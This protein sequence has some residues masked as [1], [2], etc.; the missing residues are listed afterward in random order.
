[1]SLVSPTQGPEEKQQKNIGK[2]EDSGEEVRGGLHRKQKREKVVRGG[3]KK[4]GG[5]GSQI[6]LRN[7]GGGPPDVEYLF[8]L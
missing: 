1:L 8:S 3:G 2:R 5:E 7:I 4:A 6:S